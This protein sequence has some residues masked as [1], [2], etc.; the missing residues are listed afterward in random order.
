MKKYASHFYKFPMKNVVINKIR[1]FVDNSTLKEGPKRIILIRHGE[2]IA[3]KDTK[4]YTH[5]PD[6]Q[7]PLSAKGET[8]ALEAGIKLKELVN[9]ESIKF[10][11][12]PYKRTKQ[13]LNFILK[14]FD[15]NNKEKYR[16][17]E[18]PRI[19]EQEMG[20]YQN[21][22]LI[23]TFFNERKDV[24]K[25]YYRFEYGESGADVYDRCSNFIETLYRRV[26]NLNTKSVDNL[27]LI[28]HGFFMRIFIMRFNRYDIEKFE[29]M[30]NPDNCGMWI[31]E[32]EYCN[33]Y[34]CYRYMLKTEIPHDPECM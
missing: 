18:D 21:P 2:S 8:Q 14:Q 3:N 7:I 17:L 6:N 15:V 1:H 11:V 34:E 24:G 12:S 4:I 22:E 13:T 28:T 33:N 30:G 32:K 27:V 29:Q 5:T 9:D 19:R 31:F 23:Q 25:F 26:R 16:I 20:N 10:Y